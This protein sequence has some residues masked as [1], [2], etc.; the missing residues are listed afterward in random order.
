MAVMREIMA[1]SILGKSGISDYCVNCYTG[2]LH[3]CVYCYARFMKR[4]SS[5]E[6]PWGQFLDAKINAPDIL[7][8]EVKRKTPGHVFMSSVCDA[9]QPAEKRY[10]LSRECVKILVDA[11]FHVGILTKSKLVTRDFDILQGR[12]NC[13]VSCTLTTMDEQLRFRIE[14][15]A[16]PTRERI[17][18]LERAAQLGIRI[19]AFLGPFMPELSDTDESLD[20]LFSAIAPLPLSQILADKLNPRPGV[21]NSIAPFV[22]RYRPELMQ[23][24]RRFFFDQ[25]YYG[26][27]CGDLGRRLRKIAEEHGVGDRVR[28]VF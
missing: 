13:S 5:H 18:A 15:G 7:A 1:R 10:K 14:P 8:K 25:E 17:D 16:S 2:C 20:A 22:K 6:E 28:A 11:G 21:W 19:G 12:D 9:Y 4:F 23:T 26:A 27:Y 24:Y 3:G